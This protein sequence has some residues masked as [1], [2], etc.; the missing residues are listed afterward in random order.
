MLLSIVKN[1]SGRKIKIRIALGLA[2]TTRP[3]SIP[4]IRKGIPR[5]FFAAKRSDAIK[6]SVKKITNVGARRMPV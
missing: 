6:R 5:P 2:K 3:N 4:E 1:H